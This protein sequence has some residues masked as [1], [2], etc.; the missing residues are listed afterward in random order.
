MDSVRTQGNFFTPYDDS[1]DPCG[2]QHVPESL[3]SRRLKYRCKPSGSGG[4]P[5]RF[6][7]ASREGS[8]DVKCCYHLESPYGRFALVMA[9]CIDHSFTIGID[10]AVDGLVLSKVVD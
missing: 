2:I 10:S 8:F 7:P 4:K 6:D 9:G 1:C 3:N 5:E